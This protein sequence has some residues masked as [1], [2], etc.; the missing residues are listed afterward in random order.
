MVIC[1]HPADSSSP[2]ATTESRVLPDFQSNDLNQKL[3]LRE[4][5]RQLLLSHSV[6]Q[7]ISEEIT[8]CQAKDMITC[9]DYNA[10][11]QSGRKKLWRSNPDVREREKQLRFKKTSCDQLLFKESVVSVSRVKSASEE[12]KKFCLTKVNSMFDKEW[13]CHTRVSHLNKDK[14]PPMAKANDMTFPYKPE[15][16]HLNPLEERL[17]SPITI[18]YQLR[19]LPSGGQ[20]SI[21]GNIVNV[22]CDNINVVKQFPR[23]ISETDTIPV[24]FQ[25]RLRYK[26]TFCTRIFGH[27]F[28]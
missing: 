23:R 26:S 9:K 25:R 3:L 22:P 4:L 6:K 18:F 1:V 14:M 15:I 5:N 24:K 10:V 19:E 28:V 12:L 7:R 8:A 11:N 13:I 21:K 2:A 20:F 27:T 17:V 16:M